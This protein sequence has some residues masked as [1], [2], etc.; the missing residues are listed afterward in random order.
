MKKFTLIVCMMLMVGCSHI[1]T[2]TKP[3]VCDTLEPGQESL[4]CDLSEK[5]GQTPESIAVILKVANIGYLSVRPSDAI[6]VNDFLCEVEELLIEAKGQGVIYPV[7]R[8]YVIEKYCSSPEIVQANII[9][10]RGLVEDNTDFQ[11]R[12]LTDFDINMLLYH[13]NQQKQIL[14]PFLKK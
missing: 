12:I 3:K 9:L 4:I 1:T 11:T 10:L 6:M 14:V 5:I 2:N 8:A 7:V 13:V